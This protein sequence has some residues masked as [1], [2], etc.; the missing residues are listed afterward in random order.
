MT[1]PLPHIPCDPCGYTRNDV[2]PLDKQYCVR[3]GARLPD[4]KTT[5]H[6]QLRSLKN[7]AI[8]LTT[9]AAIALIANTI[10]EPSL[11]RLILPEQPNFTPDN[12]EISLPLIAALA[13]HWTHRIA[14]I[15]VIVIFLCWLYR[16]SKNLHLITAD[17]PRYPTW[18]AIT[19]W[20]VPVLNLVLPLITVRDIWTRTNAS[21]TST[22]MPIAWWTI[23]ICATATSIPVHLMYMP[24]I[25]LLRANPYPDIS[26][27]ACLLT[28]AALTSLCTV[29]WLITAK[30]RSFIWQRYSTQTMLNPNQTRPPRWSLP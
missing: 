5:P 7:R 18:V 12:P 21:P 25:H 20:F 23:W 17:K 10:R 15:A 11:Y 26:I 22:W 27:L 13:I 14:Q 2:Q 6:A 4:V 16:A 30:Q 8:A 24:F 3:C 28:A 1:A 9:F 19:T 29:T